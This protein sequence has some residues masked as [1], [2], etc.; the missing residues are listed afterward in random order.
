MGGATPRPA[1]SRH[2]PRKSATGLGPCEESS[3]SEG[4]GEGL[5]G[6]LCADYKRHGQKLDEKSLWTHRDGGGESS[7]QTARSCAVGLRPGKRRFTQNEDRE[8]ST[9]ER[10][11]FHVD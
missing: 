1:Q 3:R 2:S 11:R 6:H 10:G 5:V 9:R 7:V 4:V 8:A